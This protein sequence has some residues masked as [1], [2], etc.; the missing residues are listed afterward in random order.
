MESTDKRVCHELTAV[1]V[2]N[3]VRRVFISPGSR[4][5]PII[6]AIARCKELQPTVVIDERSAAFMALGY[7]SV[8]GE[9]VALVCTS[10]TALLNY[11]PAIAEA[12]Y[13]R[14]ALI[15]VS[16]DRPMEWID[17]DDSQTI[18]QAGA[19]HNYVKLSCDIPEAT[20]ANLLWYANRR[21][22][23]AVLAAVTGR[24]APVHINLQLDVPLGR[25][26]DYSPGAERII[27]IVEPRQDLTVAEVRQMSLDL[28]SPRRVIIVAGFYPPDSRLNKALCR[29]AQK[30]NVAVL[31]ETISNLHGRDFI[32]R[33]DTTLSAMSADELEELRPD[34]VIT[35][36]GALVSRHIKEYLRR[37]KPQ[38]HWHVGIAHTTIDCFQGLTLRVEMD[39]G[40]FF[41]QLAAAMQPHC[42]PS[43]Y[44]DRWLHFARKGEALHQAYVA[45]APWTD[46]KA[47]A[48]LFPLIPRRWNLQLSNG[49][50]VRYAQLFGDQKQHRVDCNRGV[51][52]ID[53]STS[54][55]IGASL[56]YQG[57]ATLLIS[58][59][60]S[61]SYDVGALG[62][63]AVGGRFKMI[64]IMNG[65]GGIF[66]F[67]ASTRHLEEVD[68]YLSTEPL[69]PLKELAKGYGWDYYEAHSEEELRAAF[70]AFAA[71]SE[72]PA[73]MAIHTPSQL[74][75]DILTGYFNPL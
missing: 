19:L 39:A 26:A 52:G 17:Q 41:Q 24:R 71:P 53:G 54:T 10:G 33:I 61:A 15:V 64:V 13:R 35:L 51:S 20:T 70:P 32:S 45:R 66:R 59:D 2:A 6:V 27:R 31:T 69:L 58:G 5:A 56:A 46:L 4:N 57:D 1:L 7:A 34:V 50:A 29:M 74:S 68:Q 40:L 28:A 65:G 12:Y 44:G 49:T 8:S 55:A 72:R 48:T 60:M 18:R 25:L 67:I 16:A 22:N 62:L 14:V 43:H 75:A 30:R 42:E 73:L 36:G 63:R 37:Y 11:A 9:A 23:D 3:G 38:A 21:I 47:F